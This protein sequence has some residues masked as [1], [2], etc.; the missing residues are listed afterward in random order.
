MRQ[1]ERGIKLQIQVPGQ[2]YSQAGDIIE[3]NIAASSSGTE[4]K[5]DKQLSGKH[6]VTTIRHEFKMGADPRHQIY[7]ETVKDSLEED[8]PSAGVQYS[9][10]GSA[11]KVIV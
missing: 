3:L 7:M 2:T 1:F 11:E 6:L 4:D 5:L 9:N 8:F 10:T